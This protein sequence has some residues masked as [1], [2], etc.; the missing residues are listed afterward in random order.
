MDYLYRSS[1][2][3]TDFWLSLFRF[4]RAT[5]IPNTCT[6]SQVNKAVVLVTPQSTVHQ[7][8]PTVFCARSPRFAVF[9]AAWRRENVM[10]VNALVKR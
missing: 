2:V 1:D 6:R 5:D 7:V 8:L 10:I 3:R 9:G 4:Q